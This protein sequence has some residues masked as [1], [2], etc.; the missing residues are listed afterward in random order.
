[1]S[2]V[3]VVIVPDKNLLRELRGAV[4]RDRIVADGERAFALDEGRIVALSVSDAGPLIGAL[5]WSDR[6]IE[7]IDASTLGGRD[8]RHPRARAS[9]TPA[10]HSD[11]ARLSKKKTLTVGEAIRYLN[12]QQ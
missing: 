3:A 5:D 6:S 4:R 8:P 1:A 10:G 7:L 12:S 11:L 2:T 9:A